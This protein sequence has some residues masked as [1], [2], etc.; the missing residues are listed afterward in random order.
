MVGSC[1]LHSTSYSPRYG[2]PLFHQ[3]LNLSRN[4][5]VHIYSR[6]YIIRA[7][8]FPCYFR[9]LRHTSVTNCENNTENSKLCIILTNRKSA[10]YHE[11]MRCPKKTHKIAL[12]QPSH[13]ER[14]RF[15]VT[16]VFWAT[17]SL[18]VHVIYSSADP[19]CQP[20]WVS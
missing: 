8:T 18:F 19:H 9:I 7:W 13:A 17:V 15:G 1:V 5:H 4:N 16:D 2:R 12:I 6:P 14:I 10:S 20:V 11:F 3:T